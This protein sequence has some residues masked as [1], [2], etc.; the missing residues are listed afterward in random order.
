MKKEVIKSIRPIALFAK[1]IAY[2]PKA[3][4]QITELYSKYADVV[5]KNI[6]KMEAEDKII[7]DKLPPV[8]RVLAYQ[9]WALN[10]SQI[11]EINDIYIKLYRKVIEYLVE[12]KDDLNFTRYL[13]AFNGVLATSDEIEILFTHF[14]IFVSANNIPFDLTDKNFVN[15]LS[16]LDH[17]YN[18][19]VTHI[20]GYQY[21]KKAYKVYQEYWQEVN[22]KTINDL[23]YFNDYYSPYFSL[24]GNIAK[25]ENFDFGRI[26]GWKFSANAINSIIK[27]YTKLNLVPEDNKEDFK[28][29]IA[30]ALII[31]A[32]SRYATQSSNAYMDIALKNNKIIETKTIVDTTAITQLSKENEKL[33]QQISK[34]QVI[35]EQ[36]EKMTEQEQQDI[37]L[38]ETTSTSP[39]DIST[40][41]ILFVGGMEHTIAQ[42]RTELPTVEFLG[43]EDTKASLRNINSYDKVVISHKHLSHKTFY[44][45]I[46]KLEDKNKLVYVSTTNLDIL[47]AKIGQ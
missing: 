21:N 20:V 40:L 28:K 34:Q 46:D 14:A 19:K 9:V 8:Q 16:W 15:L 11:K 6:Q 27:E 18:P 12:N 29:F 23:K 32:M 24:L 13:F 42:I 37:L 10:Y 7:L 45:V 22:A 44:R 25:E 26:E 31:K 41:K 17:K 36:Y 39:V 1:A 43:R 47:K 2:N 38:P 4:K 30:T 3:T 5:S 33:Q 35:I